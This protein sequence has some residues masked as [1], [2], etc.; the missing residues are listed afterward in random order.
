MDQIFVYIF[1]VV[2][3]GLILVFGYK[4][5]QQVMH[6]GEDVEFIKFLTDFR[7][8]TDKYYYLA[9][10]S[11]KK[12]SMRI[13]PDVKE[14]CFVGDDRDFNYENE[15]V[16]VL[17]KSLKDKNMFFVM[18]GDK[19]RLE[20]QKIEHLKPAENPLCIKSSLGMLNYKLTTMQDYVEINN[21]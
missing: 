18:V 14:V 9:E 2:V 13:G 11:M 19:E 15:E 1:L 12:V 6:T 5:I 16:N 3:A 10:G 17:M 7:K 21:V 4:G 20:A 8:E